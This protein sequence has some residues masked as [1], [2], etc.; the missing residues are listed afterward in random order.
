MGTK[1]PKL[2]VVLLYAQQFQARKSSNI[3]ISLNKGIATNKQ[4]K[5][6]F[7]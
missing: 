1:V 5:N 4:Y 7:E 2:N 6:I 3:G